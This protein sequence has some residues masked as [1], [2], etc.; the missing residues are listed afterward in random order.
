MNCEKCA[1]EIHDKNIYKFNGELFC[2]DCFIDVVIGVPQVDISNL[3]P[4]VKAGFHN[5]M[6]R[7]NRDRPN[8]HHI[9]FHNF[10][11]ENK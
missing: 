8:R 1:E 5:I 3:P 6:K 9:I 2:D 11:E 4:Q 10:G 7:W